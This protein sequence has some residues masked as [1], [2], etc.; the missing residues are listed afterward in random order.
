MWNVV[1]SGAR[2]DFESV[3]NVSGRLV[4]SIVT[5]VIDPFQ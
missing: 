2:P 3:V 1:D 4:T 5:G